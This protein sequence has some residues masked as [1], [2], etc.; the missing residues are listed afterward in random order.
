VIREIFMISSEIG[1]CVVLGNLECD[2]YVGQL[3]DGDFIVTAAGL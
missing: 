2:Y 1:V 3:K